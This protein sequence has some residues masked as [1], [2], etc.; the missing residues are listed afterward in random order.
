MANQYRHL[1]LRPSHVSTEN[2]MSPKRGDKKEP[3]IRE[4]SEH[5]SRLKSRLD[6]AWQEAQ[7]R[8]EERKALG[9]PMHD[10]VYISIEG[11]QGYELPI[12]SLEDKKKGIRIANAYFENEVHYAVLFVP[13]RYRNHLLQKIEDYKN[14][15]KNQ[16]LVATIN[17]IKT[18]V[19]ESFWTEAPDLIPQ[20]NKKWCELWL[21]VLNEDENSVPQ[22][23][24]NF[25]SLAETFGIE[26]KSHELQ[27][28]ERTVM[29]AR[30]NG[31]DIV[32]LIES[33]PAIAEFRLAK[34]P[35]YLYYGSV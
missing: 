30:L 9:L 3:P 19:I 7:D 12:K 14:K 28:P 4:H 27:F 31:E 10:G 5:G 8:G 26:L 13:M 17:D 23:V 34:E 22:T 21:L 15:G 6:N 25:K 16:A 29:M 20:Q 32:N 11:E 1:F 33:S 24:E 18:A 35:A 2:Y